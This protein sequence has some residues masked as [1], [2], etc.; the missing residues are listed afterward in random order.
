VRSFCHATDGYLDLPLPLREFKKPE[1]LRK[2]AE[3]GKL[4]AD[5]GFALERGPVILTGRPLMDERKD[6]ICAC[7][8]SRIAARRI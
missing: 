3:P 4:S 1:K 2:P 8:S 7:A 6:R 5:P